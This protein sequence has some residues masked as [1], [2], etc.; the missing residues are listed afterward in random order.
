MGLKQGFVHVKPA[1][2]QIHNLFPGG[3]REARRIH[4]LLKDLGWLSYGEPLILY[5][6]IYPDGTG[7]FRLED[8]NREALAVVNYNPQKAVKTVRN[9][10]IPGEHVDKDNDET[11]FRYR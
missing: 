8:L 7:G 5:I 3:Y 10:V 11:Y 9:L 1:H 6:A 4:Y 2:D